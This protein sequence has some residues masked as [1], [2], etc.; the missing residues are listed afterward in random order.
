MEDPIDRAVRVLN[1]ALEADPKAINRLMDAQV[2]VND[3]LAAHPSIQVGE[4]PNAHGL[5]MRPLGLINGLFGTS[6]RSTSVIWTVRP[7]T[8]CGSSEYPSNYRRKPMAEPTRFPE[9][10][11]SWQG[12]P[13]SAERDEV[14]DL[15]AYRMNDLTISCWQMGWRERI[16]A[17]LTGKVWLHVYGRQPPV[18][19]GGD[20]PFG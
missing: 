17:F 13:K 5:R 1:E 3:A 8:S 10:N 7:A 4:R 15:P 14:G 19:V 11:A 2:P 12:W 20:D 16:R 6:P 18:Y 9:V